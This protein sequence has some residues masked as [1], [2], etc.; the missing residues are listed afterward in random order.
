M[1]TIP[2]IRIELHEIGDYLIAHG[3]ARTGRRV[4][5]L[6]AATTRRSPS[7]RARTKWPKLSPEQQREIRE[8]AEAYPDDPVQDIAVLFETNAGRI[9]EALNGKRQ[10][11]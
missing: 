5:E 4:H 9:S 1:K 7:R 6:A 2:Q 8:W 11:A 3:M 10:D